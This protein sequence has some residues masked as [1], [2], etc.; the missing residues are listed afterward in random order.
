MC[1]AILNTKGTIDRQTFQTC[2]NNNPDGGGIAWADNGKVNIIKE[3]KSSDILFERYVELRDKFPN[4]NFL[5]HFRIATH[6]KV[7]ETNCHPFKVNKQLAF[8]HNG[9]IDGAGLKVSTEF[10]DTYLFN[11]LILQKL[12]KNFTENEAILN[13]LSEYIG[14]SK[15]VFLDSRDNWAIVNENLGTWDGDN[16]FSNN[17]YLDCAVVKTSKKGK[18]YYYDSYKDYDDYY[19]GYD[20]VSEVAKDSYCDCC[21]ES[22]DTR[23]VSAYNAEMCDTCM[24]EMFE[25]DELER[26]DL[27]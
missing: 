12:P 11:Q 20:Y 14:Y 24:K 2:W 1:I 8:I 15:L 18:S 4:N 17:S 10:S 5:I 27:K 3:M 23:Y 22:K 25:I 9:M 6:G 26:Y 19:G 21:N 13:L 7:N 16:W